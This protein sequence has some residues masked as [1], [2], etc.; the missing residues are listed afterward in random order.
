MRVPLLLCDPPPLISTA[1]SPAKVQTM[2]KNSKSVSQLVTVLF[3]KFTW[4]KK[5]MF[6]TQLFSPL[7]TKKCIH[8]GRQR[9]PMRNELTGINSKLA[10]TP[11]L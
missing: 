7:L 6:T 1:F 10:S 2:V 5:L 4:Q 11:I 9:V 8:A 3:T